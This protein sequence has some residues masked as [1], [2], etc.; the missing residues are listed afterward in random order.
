MPCPDDNALARL[1]EGT[2]TDPERLGLEQH[3]DGCAACSELL[4]QI[5]RAYAKPKTRAEARSAKPA[6]GALGWLGWLAL[7]AALLEGLVAARLAQLALE[8]QGAFA[9]ASSFASVWLGIGALSGLCAAI[10]IFRDRSWAKRWLWSYALL[11]LPSL[12][13]TPVALCILR[14]LRRPA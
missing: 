2:L 3:L 14:E 10:G 7:G 9:V 5:G 8:L 1:L 13:F 6:L 11:A 12:A 4:A